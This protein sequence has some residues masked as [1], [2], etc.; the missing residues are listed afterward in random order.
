MSNLAE[1]I[2]QE[3]TS[4]MDRDE[5]ELPSLPEVA[6][7]IRDEA[8]NCLVSVARMA[9]PVGEVGER[10]VERLVLKLPVQR[11]LGGHVSGRD[12]HVAGG[13]DGQAP[14][15]PARPVGGQERERLGSAGGE[16][17]FDE[18]GDLGHERFE[19]RRDV[20][21]TGEFGRRRGGLE[22]GD[23]G[24]GRGSDVWS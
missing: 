8:E 20:H 16:R 15:Q 2:Q 10:V 24:G 3:V 19:E 13:A 22:R 9:E 18:R 23:R 11:V 4:A 21:L 17:S 12:E 6:L 14:A 5:L 1:Q 7:R